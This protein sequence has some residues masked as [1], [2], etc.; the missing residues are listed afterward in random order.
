MSSLTVLSGAVC[1]FVVVA[2][3]YY[4]SDHPL[5]PFTDVPA[6]LH[7]APNT[8][9]VSFLPTDRRRIPGKETT[10]PEALATQIDLRALDDSIATWLTAASHLEQGNPAA[11]SPEQKQERVLLQ[12][13]QTAVRNQISSGLITDTFRRVRNESLQLQG[14]NTRW[15]KTS[16]Q[17]ESARFF[18]QGVPTHT[19]LTH[20]QYREFRG[21]IEDGFHEIQGY[22]QPDPLQRVRLQ[23]IQTIRTDLDSLDTPSIR[24]GD[25]RTF[26]QAML[27][28][29]QPLPSLC[30]IEAFTSNP[31][32]NNRLTQTP[33]A[34]PDAASDTLAP[35]HSSQN[36][37][38]IVE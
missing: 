29:D 5:E 36:S 30:S 20:D 10:P 12:A 3:L 24:M 22:L 37:M 18:G 31:T 23:Q 4:Q 13:R 8:L 38:R 33:N 28:P 11:L 27:E 21:L 32:S 19:M 35:I 14:E 16:S 2:I 7:R 1:V 26:L 15:G 25:A 34:F 6:D 9:P 17:L